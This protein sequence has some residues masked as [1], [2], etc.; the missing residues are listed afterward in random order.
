[1]NRNEELEIRKELQKVL[2]DT[3]NDYKRIL[4]L[5][6]QL[7][8]KDVEYVRFSVD[9]GIINRLGNELV[10][11][12]ETAVGELIKNAYDADA[13]QVDMVFERAWTPGG[14]LRIE[15]TGNGMTREQLING[16]M[17]LSSASKI[18]EPYS[19]VFHRARAGKKGIGRFA[20]QRL[21]H[22]LTIITQTENDSYALKVTFDWKRFVTDTELWSVES[23]IE[24]IKKTKN[25]GTDLIID[26][27][28]EGWTDA[29]LSKTN[30]S[31]MALLQPYPIGKEKKNSVDPGIQINFY[32]DRIS[33][34]TKV[35][36]SVESVYSLALA[37]INGEVGDN[38]VALWSVKSTRLGYEECFQSDVDNDKEKNIYPL[39]KGVKLKAY[40][41]IYES[42]LFPRGAMK[43]VNE[44][45][46]IYGGIRI[47]RNGFRVLPY[48]EK[49]NDWLGLDES[50]TRRTILSPHQN[51]NFFGLV[52]LKGEYLLQE[53]EE[54]ASREGLIE[55]EAYNELVQCVYQILISAVL[56]VSELRGRK[57]RA[58]QKG[59][60]KNPT[61]KVDAALD[62]LRNIFNSN[63]EKNNTTNEQKGTS[64]RQEFYNQAKS[65][66]E[67]IHSK[68]QEERKIIAALLDENKML[69]VLASVGLI[70][71][72]FVHEVKRFLPAFR[73]S[74][75][76]IKKSTG[77][78]L[79]IQ[80]EIGVLEHQIEGFTSYTSYFE[81]NISQ[82]IIRQLV[83]IAPHKQVKDFIN[84][85]STDL[86]RAGI[87]MESPQLNG[88]N[89]RTVPMHPSEWMSILFNL[90]TNSK[91]AIYKSL[92]MDKRIY[93][94]V[95]EDSKNVVL[96]FSD[97]G[98]GIPERDWEKV[99]NAFFTTSS[100]VNTNQTQQDISGSGLGLKIVRDIVESYGGTIM[101]IPPKD[102]YATTIKLT[103]PKIE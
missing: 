24:E 21:G 101:V 34:E 61:I 33:D 13:T 19:P 37:E 53:F 56:K 15:D 41:Y 28:R 90:Y 89:L 4:E 97:T 102:G 51:I 44:S 29:L 45:A 82:N 10:G 60:D 55:N 75:D 69:R 12:S 73:N 98:I 81:S 11:K 59:W 93:I 17:R 70:V 2:I 27:L 22:R 77:D 86:N 95:T 63:Q 79:S 3:P 72:E 8:A 16:F 100:P 91:K 7:A 25:K 85:V 49:D 80:E 54:T 52:E 38:G 84:I 39:L 50:V 76:T 67:E 31:I 5:S 48:G 20:A 1:M 83:P 6:N 42:S 74:I 47:Y 87:V 58:D 65:L 18:N 68:R 9:S 92:K 99:F 96:E 46:S 36:D 23:K 35:I 40:Y 57:G 78:N 64:S 103:I 94:S 88:I 14:T 66:I 26:D 30:K 62:E 43:Y 32:R 71:G